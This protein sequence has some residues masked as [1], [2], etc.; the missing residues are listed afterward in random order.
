MTMSWSGCGI[1]NMRKQGACTCFHD[2]VKSH[3]TPSSSP[4]QSHPQLSLSTDACAKGEKAVLLD[5]QHTLRGC[6]CWT[7]SFKIKSCSKNKQT[8]ITLP[9]AERWSN[10]FLQEETN[11]QGIRAMPHSRRQM[12][13]HRF[14]MLLAKQFFR[15]HIAEHE[16]YPQPQ[17]Q[18]CRAII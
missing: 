16:Q 9:S 2:L 5:V 6:F 8:P 7:L 18:S 4:P 3:L 17:M 15:T 14:W 10:C 11:L 12:W 1:M 13:S